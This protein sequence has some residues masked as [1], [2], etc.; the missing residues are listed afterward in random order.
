MLWALS[1]CQ[2]RIWLFIKKGSF[3]KAHGL[4]IRDWKVS[5]LGQVPQTGLFL[6][7]VVSPHQGNKPSS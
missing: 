2:I 3:L 7:G 6:L 5:H 4:L 1:P